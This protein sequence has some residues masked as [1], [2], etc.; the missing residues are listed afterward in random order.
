MVAPEPH[1][2]QF[3]RASQGVFAAEVVRPSIECCWSA[4][5]FDTMWEYVA[6]QCPNASSVALSPLPER[7]L[8]L[9]QH[10]VSPYDVSR[11]LLPGQERDE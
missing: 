7:G 10:R 8:N 4:R 11:W 3:R 9:L 5:D 2:S 6:S 1:Y